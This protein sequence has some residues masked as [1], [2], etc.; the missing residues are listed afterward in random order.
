MNLAVRHCAA[1][2]RAAQFLF[3]SL[4]AKSLH[5]AGHRK[6][7]GYHWISGACYRFNH[8]RHRGALIDRAAA[9]QEQTRLHLQRL[10]PSRARHSLRYTGIEWVFV[11]AFIRRM[12][13][14]DV[15]GKPFRFVRLVTGRPSV[16][17]RFTY[18]HYARWE[19]DGVVL[20]RAS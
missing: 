8:A 15:D 7:N 1:A 6:A 18:C 16:R 20:A 9:V 13:M 14:P 3:A 4:Y 17:V 10:D 5:P 11:A 12:A 2:S 19:A